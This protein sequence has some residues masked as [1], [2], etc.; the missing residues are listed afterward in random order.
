MK[1]VMKKT[2]E[3]RN[4]QR[5]EESIHLKGEAKPQM[6]ALLHESN[7]H[8]YKNIPT[9]KHTFL[10]SLLLLLSLHRSLSLGTHIW[11]FWQFSM[12]DT[13]RWCCTL[14]AHMK[15]VNLCAILLCLLAL[16]AFAE[17]QRVILGENIL[18][19]TISNLRLR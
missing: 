11:Q 8:A 14:C 19:S 9:T 18:R 5:K 16:C 15:T 3:R 7:K 4:E 2:A 1:S 10:F 17:F 13:L 6:H 12:A